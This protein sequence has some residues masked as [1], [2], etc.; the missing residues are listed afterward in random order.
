MSI[1]LPRVLP[2]IVIT[3]SFVLWT[4]MAPNVASAA[5][6]CAVIK[7]WLFRS[8][9]DAQGFVDLHDLRNLRVTDGLL[10]MEITGPDAYLSLPPVDLPLD[11]LSVRVRMRCDR[12]GQS[13]LYWVAHDKPEWSQSRHAAQFTPA[14]A[15]TG[16]A[17]S[18]GGFL[19]VEFPIGSIA[20]AGRRLTG[21]RL[22][23]YNGN[24]AG[25]VEIASIEVC[26]CPP[27]YMAHF[28]PTACRVAL[29]APATFRATLR[30]VAGKLG[31]GDAEISI[32]EPTP[33]FA[34]RIRG[35]A[36]RERTLERVMR[37]DRAGVRHISSRIL[38]SE[39]ES[40]SPR[41][42]P[43]GSRGHR[44]IAA[45]AKPVF[46]LE[47]SVI[48]GEGGTL[49][50]LGGARTDRVRV[51]LI[52]TADGRRIGAGRWQVA[53]GDGAFRQA[54]WLLPL[55]ELTVEHP[56]GGIVRR[57]P[58]LT[59][60]R[61]AA[62]EVRLAATVD[63]GGPWRIEV[64][65]RPAIAEGIPHVEVT[66]ALDGPDGGKLLD[67]SGP[68]LRADRDDPAADPLDRFAVFGGLEFLE[69]G[70]RSSS[71]R[72]VGPKFADRWTPH[73][74]KVCL[75]VMAVEAG[76]LTTSLMWQPLEPWSEDEA[77]PTATFA[78]PDFLDGQACHLMKLS[79]PSIPQWRQENEDVARRPFAMAAGKRIA[80]RYVL[81]GEFD[82][83]AAMA[84]RTWYRIFGLP[85][86]P[87]TPRDDR[88]TW[89]LYARHLGET[90]YWPEEK[91]WRQHWY[92]GQQ[93]G[94][95]PWMAAELLAH[96]A[97]T[98]DRQWVEAA[99]IADKR[100]VETAGPLSER[101]ADSTAAD[102]AIRSVRP[103]GTWAYVNTPKV[104][105]EA[106]RMTAGTFDSLGEDGSTSLGTCAMNAL[107]I[108]HYALLTG[109]AEYIRAGVEALETMRQFRVPRGAQ[110]WEVH[111]DIPDIRAAALAVEAYRLGY[112]ITDDR[113]WLDEAGG[114]AWAGVPFLYSWEVPVDRN[115]GH[116]IASR[117][118]NAGFQQL[119]LLPL[120]EAFEKPRRQVTPFGSIP[121]LGP[122]YYVMN[123]FGV[124]VQ[125][126]GLEWAL[127]V[128]EL[129]RD[130]PDPLLRAIADG[131]VAS[132][133]QQ[134]FDRPPWVGLYPDVWDTR[135]N[136]A[137]GAF[138]CGM[139]PMACLQAQG[140]IP[141]RTHPW[142]IVL[143]DSASRNRWHISGWGRRPSLK[144]P[145]AGTP[146]FVPVEFIEGEPNELVIVGA[147]RPRL[148]LVGE[149]AIDSAPADTTAPELTSWHYDAAL[150][151]IIVRFTQPKRE[152]IVRVEW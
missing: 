50:T 111:K 81:V 102:G 116:L 126:C 30:Q 145:I 141:D 19:T 69:P 28:A 12:G 75:P 26:Q 58:A 152:A 99:G 54:G 60:V 11:G 149:K 146:L 107:P 94:F 71:D 121:V 144:W 10:V 147:D 14:K 138:I 36:T 33:G 49:P 20:D 109:R 42:P 104:R 113:R 137:Q 112:R 43:A 86:P 61:Q 122:T 85:R 110:V 133:L 21:L 78:S 31:G 87:A 119:G 15:V 134:T 142:T 5:D 3:V 103:D 38:P 53:G 13:E 91:G 22:D 120:S 123:W 63:E 66:A 106:K 40:E 32:G 80:L 68:T 51:D 130:R 118:R 90:M 74:F 131:V 136:T 132:G 29:D 105:E 52:P 73:P 77:M 70:W 25:L 67:F 79:A 64:A 65:I 88:T 34:K 151:A 18:D 139:L 44:G 115:P 127:K 24:T 17:P 95:T 23:P 59:I 4:G 124:I 92:L 47:S 27:V 150:R 101:I 96:A 83:P 125:W 148:V 117:D 84:A 82:A 1:R 7:Q 97:V 6:E 98:G 57:Q 140:R 37:F 93:S 55:A 143:R 35:P 108:L 9:T 56:F 72:A 89:N 8:T 46:T 100:I 135:T 128:I 129:D 114:W 76:G 39:D 16:S 41:T 48:V 2:S 45:G 62:D